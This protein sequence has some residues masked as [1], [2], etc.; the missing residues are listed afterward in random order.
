MMI[1]TII[2]QRK[3]C[4]WHKFCE[5]SCNTESKGQK[6]ILL[7]D[8]GADSFNYFAKVYIL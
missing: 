6:V 1:I 7:H 2:P 5:Y 3:M 8:I 4:V